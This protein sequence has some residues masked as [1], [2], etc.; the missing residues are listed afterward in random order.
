MALGSV[1]LAATLAAGDALAGSAGND[2]GAGYT[3]DKKAAAAYAKAKAAGADT[4]PNPREGDA[5][6]IAAG[7][8]LFVSKCATCHGESAD[9]K[10]PAAIA[11]DPPP[12]SFVDP[13]RWAAN[14]PGTRQWIIQNGIQGTGMVP[15]GITEDEAWSVLAYLQAAYHP[16][17]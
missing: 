8:D 16:S 9:G 1:C 7:K 2:T 6:A 15:P 14:T 11:L 4:R 10:G 13:T 17:N 5:A 3:P 12:A